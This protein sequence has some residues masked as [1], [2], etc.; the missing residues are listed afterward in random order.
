[1][2]D[3][4]KKKKK[5]KMDYILKGG[6][7]V[8]RTPVPPRKRMWYERQKIFLNGVLEFDEETGKSVLVQ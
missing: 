3:V 8:D 5:S 6:E 2:E 7:M 4:T 1:M